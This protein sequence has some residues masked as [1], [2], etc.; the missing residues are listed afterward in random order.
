MNKATLDMIN[1][2]ENCYI[3]DIFLEKEIKRR[4]AELGFLEKSLVKCVLE[5]PFKEPRAYRIKDTTIALRKEITKN[6]LV[7]RI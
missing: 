2:G 4:L 3:I 1:V 5:G 7:E 6:I